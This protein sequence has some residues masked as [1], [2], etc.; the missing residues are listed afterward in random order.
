VIWKAENEEAIG[1]VGPQRRKKI[2]LEENFYE[3]RTHIPAK[4]N[5]QVI[6]I[7]YVFKFS[8]KKTNG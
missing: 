1:R 3:H 8:R 6:G 5:P 4:K 7:I 2:I